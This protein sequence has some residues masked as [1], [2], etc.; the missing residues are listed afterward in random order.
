MMQRLLRCKVNY[1][2]HQQFYYHKKIFSDINTT[3]LFSKFKIIATCDTRTRCK[4]QLLYRNDHA[5]S[6]N[7]VAPGRNLVGDVP[8]FLGQAFLNEKIRQLFEA[9]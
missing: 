6:Y 5:K 2:M 8:T 7:I 1:S 3:R 4:G 9:R